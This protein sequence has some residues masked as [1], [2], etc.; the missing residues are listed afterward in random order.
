MTGAR[1]FIC[2]SFANCPVTG[3]GILSPFISLFAFCG[4]FKTNTETQLEF[5]PDHNVGIAV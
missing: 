5:V 2:I 4:K 1:C 3:L